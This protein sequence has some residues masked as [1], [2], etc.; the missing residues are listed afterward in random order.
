MARPA[1]G[2]FGRY[3]G[4]QLLAYALE[5]AVYL[6]VRAVGLGPLPSNAV[7]KAVALVFAFFCHRSFTFRSQDSRVGQQAVR[8]FATFLVNVVISTSLLWLLDRYLPEWIAKGVSDVVA[9]FVSYLL[10]KR[11]VF[12]SGG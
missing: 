8:Y 12:R 4:V 3:V 6:G 10:A 5:W 7:G 1:V 2:E 9:V 11:I